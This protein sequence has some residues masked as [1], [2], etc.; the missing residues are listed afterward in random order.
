MA[1]GLSIVR[2]TYTKVI[3]P[4]WYPA[5]LI[6]VLYPGKYGYGTIAGRPLLI[7]RV[8]GGTVLFHWL[9]ICMHTDITSSPANQ[10]LRGSPG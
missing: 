9:S 1:T 6:Q 2:H 5:V 3:A 7:V 4:V 10:I 8:M